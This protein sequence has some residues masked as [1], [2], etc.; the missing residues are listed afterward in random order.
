MEN[1]LDQLKTGYKS[2]IAKV[3]D[4]K[5]EHDQE[6]SFASD[7]DVA[8]P[9]TAAAVVVE[10]D[11]PVKA[12]TKNLGTTII[13]ETTVINGDLKSDSHI[14]VLGTITGNVEATGHVSVSGC[15][16][17]NIKAASL[18]ID[19]GTVDAD[20]IEADGDVSINPGA[21]IKSNIKCNNFFLGAKF[22]GS[23]IAQNSIVFSPSSEIIGDVKAKNIDV[24]PGA[25]TDGQ[26]TIVKK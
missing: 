3:S 1:K 14:A 18:T 25:A 7:Y 19:G 16:T 26:I 15:V 23:V 24:K 9:S 21:H 12:P 11:T 8:V 2:W 17:G 22:V 4:P 13:S 20:T 5:E 10:V 6:A